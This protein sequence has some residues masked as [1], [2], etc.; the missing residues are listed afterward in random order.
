ME[1]L[2]PLAASGGSDHV[3]LRDLT[4]VIPSFVFL[5]VTHYPDLPKPAQ[6]PRP[7]PDSRRRALPEG[8]NRPAVTFQKTALKE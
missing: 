2:F 6:R 1:R 3:E 4:M 5:V 8:S 7:R